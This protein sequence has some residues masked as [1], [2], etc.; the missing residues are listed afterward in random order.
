MTVSI[1]CY[2]YLEKVTNRSKKKNQR[3]KNI[4]F[5]YTG[6]QEVNLLRKKKTPNITVLFLPQKQI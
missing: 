5:S 3:V 6:I 2:L 4:P 1:N